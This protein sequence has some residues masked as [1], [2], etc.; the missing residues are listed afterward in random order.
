MGLRGSHEKT[1]IDDTAKWGEEQVARSYKWPKK[2]K[3]GVQ[4]GLSQ[5]KD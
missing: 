4:I 1:M 5:T 3:W 2:Q